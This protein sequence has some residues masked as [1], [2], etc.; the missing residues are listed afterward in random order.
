YLLIQDTSAASTRRLRIDQAQA[1]LAA[2][3]QQAYE[4]GPAPEI[5]TDPSRGPISVKTYWDPTSGETVPSAIVLRV[6]AGPLGILEGLSLS[7][8][9]LSCAEDIEIKPA[10]APTGEAGKVLRLHGGDSSDHPAGGRVS[11]A[12]GSG[13]SGQGEVQ[14]NTGGGNIVS[15]T[16]DTRWEHLGSLRVGR[17]EERRVGE[18]SGE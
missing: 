5:T 18:G 7:P 16:I 1:A 10:E 17:S 3:L 15:G 13:H 6:D 12:A 11:I 14:I 8:A 2:S 9:G 4:A